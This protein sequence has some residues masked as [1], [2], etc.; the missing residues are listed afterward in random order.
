MR[1]LQLLALAA[2]L[3]LAAPAPAKN[4]T[5]AKVCGVDGCQQIDHPTEQLL[6][7]GP[8]TTGPSAPGPFVRFRYELGGGREVA[9]NVFVPRVGLVL[10]DD[11][12]TWMHPAALALIRRLAR[13]VTPF[14]ASR[15]P[16]GALV[17]AAPPVARPVPADRTS[18][19]WWGLLGSPVLLALG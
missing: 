2:A 18:D 17:P 7:G 13:R 12:H 9:S 6:M 3:A 10:A 1:R 15:F 16:A 4:V 19:W 8:G 11:G 14:P 5:S